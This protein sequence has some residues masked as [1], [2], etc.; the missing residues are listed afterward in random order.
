MERTVRGQAVL[1][2][3]STPTN[4]ELLTNLD[5]LSDERR[6]HVAA[7]GRSIPDF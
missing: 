2:S 1:S 7:A 4:T 6:M 5:A 3:V